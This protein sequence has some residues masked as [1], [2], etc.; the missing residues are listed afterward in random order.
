[1]LVDDVLGDIRSLSVNNW[2]KFAQDIDTWKEVDV[3]AR[4][5]YRL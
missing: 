3:R 4:A 1:M 5:L 2:K